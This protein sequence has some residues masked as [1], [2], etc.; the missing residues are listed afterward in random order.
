MSTADDYHPKQTTAQLIDSCQANLH[1]LNRTL[2]SDEQAM[3]DQIRNYIDQS[4]SA[5]AE[6]DLDRAH[7]LAL[8]AHLLC[9]EL[10]KP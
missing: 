4:R 7:N 10:V 5:A 9:D 8:K 2:S 6:N 3:L 1:N